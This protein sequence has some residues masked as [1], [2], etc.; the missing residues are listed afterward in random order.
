MTIED[1]RTEITR[2]ETELEEKNELLNEAEVDLASAEEAVFQAEL[3][4][5]FAKEEVE[6]AKD[7]LKANREALERL[8]SE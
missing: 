2:L 8:E 3:D 1:C 5:G 4:V 6:E 7:L